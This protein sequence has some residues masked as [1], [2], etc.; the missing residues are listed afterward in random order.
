MILISLS[1]S[2]LARDINLDLLTLSLIMSALAY[3]LDHIALVYRSHPRPVTLTTSHLIPT[4]TVT[5]RTLTEKP[6][7]K[8]HGSYHWQAER[9]L[10]VAVL[11]L[12]VIPIVAGPSSTVD[13]LLGFLMPL[14]CHL[15]FGQIIT[16]YLN[17]RKIGSVGS[18]LVVATL[19]AATALTT[20]GL[21][22]FNTNDIGITEFV[23]RLWQG[24]QVSNKEKVEK[25]SA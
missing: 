4:P 17:K 18:G 2:L 10:S 14:H 8:M 19:Y 9:I 3:S 25:P 7:D 5:P 24:K 11:P 23:K 6:V 16:D 1:L 20:Y 13:F 21:Y 15:G 22:Q 12:C